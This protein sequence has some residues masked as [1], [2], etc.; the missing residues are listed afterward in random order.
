MTALFEQFGLA[1]KQKKGDVSSIFDRLSSKNFLRVR[2]VLYSLFSCRALM[3]IINDKRNY[4][5]VY[6]RT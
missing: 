6:F 5:T 1:M 4:L 2:V 3:M